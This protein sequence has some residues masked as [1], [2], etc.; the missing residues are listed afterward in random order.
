[1][2]FEGEAMDALDALAGEPPEKLFRPADGHLCSCLLEWDV[3]L[4]V[5]TPGAGPRTGVLHRALRLG[6]PVPS[7]A[8]DEESLTVTL[9]LD[10]RAYGG[11]IPATSRRP[12]TT[13]SADC[14][15]GTACGRASRAPGR[16]TARRAGR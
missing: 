7:G 1:M 15:P 11:E 5:G 12:C 3:P 2:P 4:T 9:R 8:V 6:D 13:S 14:R 10:G 16:T